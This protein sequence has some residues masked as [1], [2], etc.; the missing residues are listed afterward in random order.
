MSLA[1]LFQNAFA[2]NR[3]QPADVLERDRTTGPWVIVE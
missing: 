1:F 3:L 2:R